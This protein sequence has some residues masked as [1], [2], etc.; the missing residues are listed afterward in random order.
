MKRNGW[1]IFFLDEKPFPQQ[2]V[3]IQESGYGE[4]GNNSNKKK[5]TSKT[6]TNLNIIY[7]YLLN[8]TNEQK[9]FVSSKNGF[10]C[11]CDETVIHNVSVSITLDWP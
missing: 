5:I 2:V 3:Q 11:E 8:Y 10:Q 6:E 4:G 1:H 9:C 7:G